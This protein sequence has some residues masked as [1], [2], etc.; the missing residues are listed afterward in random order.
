MEMRPS[1]RSEYV[2]RRNFKKLG[3]LFRGK[4]NVGKRFVLLEYTTDIIECANT[5]NHLPT[6]FYEDIC[7]EPQKKNMKSLNRDHA[8]QM[9]EKEKRMYPD[10]PV[11]KIKPVTFDQAVKEMDG[12]LQRLKIH[13]SR[14]GY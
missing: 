11:K 13:R 7:A 1:L 2:Q 8:K 6:T 14:L 9:N 4:L 5:L 12:Q 3:H 10:V